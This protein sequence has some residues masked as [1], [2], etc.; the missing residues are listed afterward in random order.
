MQ[1]GFVRVLLLKKTSRFNGTVRFSER[2]T[3]GAHRITI[4]GVGNN[5]RQRKKLG[6]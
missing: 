3:S 1:F 5:E 6:F 4:F 2:S